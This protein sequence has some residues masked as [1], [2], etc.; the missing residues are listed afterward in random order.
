MRDRGIVRAESEVRESE[1][2]RREEDRE[3]VSEKE[4][5]RGVGRE[6]LGKERW[7]RER[8]TDRGIGGMEN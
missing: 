2:G 5:E 7:E 6:R 8:K 3:W 4:I 1:G